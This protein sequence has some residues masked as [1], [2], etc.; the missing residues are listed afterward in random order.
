MW[1]WIGHGRSKEFE[2]WGTEAICIYRGLS[3]KM[4]R[5]QATQTWDDGTAF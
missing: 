3:N 2:L 4:V 5:E 1:H